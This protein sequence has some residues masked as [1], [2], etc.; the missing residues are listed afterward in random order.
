MT[1]SSLPDGASSDLPSF[2]RN[3]LE[4]LLD[5]WESFAHQIEPSPR[6]MSSKELRNR[7]RELLESISDD[8]MSEQSRGESTRKSRGELSE[9]APDLTATAREHGAQRSGHGFNLNEVVA[10]YRALRASVV[11]NWLRATEDEMATQIAQLVRFDEALDQSL[12]ESIR[13]HH[14]LETSSRDIFVGVLGH[15]LRNPLHAISAAAEVLSISNQAPDRDILDSISRNCDRMRSMI[16]DL[17]DFARTRLGE[18]MPLTR[19][20]SSLDELCERLAD[21]FRLRH[22]DRRIV[23]RCSGDLRGDWDV[24]Q[25]ERMLGN[26]VSNALEHGA[27]DTPVTIQADG[28]GDG[29]VLGVHNEGNPIPQKMRGVIFD[30]LRRAAPDA[31]SVSRRRPESMGLGLY[32]VRE[33]A[34]AHGGDVSFSSSPESGT[35][36]EV[37]VPRR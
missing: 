20:A 37:A 21:D 31:E 23:V 33:I 10:E 15:D 36:F 11:R 16:A 3:N 13:R 2:I 34:L 17:L 19:R 26:L 6:S 4:L 1:Q 22:P 12:T 32:I 28:Q 7:V 18:G 5:E 14:E 29:V 27:D 8:M 9:N 35:R 25:M 30:P 24:E